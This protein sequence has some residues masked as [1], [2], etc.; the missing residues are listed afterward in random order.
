VEPRDSAIKRLVKASPLGPLAR[1]AAKAY[2]VRRRLILDQYDREVVE[3]MSRVLRKDSNCV[4]AGAH[5]GKILRHMLRL[6]PEGTH[7]AFEPL[8]GLAGELRGA[9]PSAVVMEMA[10]ANVTE[11]ARFRHVL[12]DEAYSGFKRRPWDTYEEAVEMIEVQVRPLDEVLPPELP[13]HFIKADVE[14]SEYQLLQGAVRTLTSNRPYVAFELGSDQEQIFDLLS[15]TGLGTFLLDGWL[16]GSGPL[17][18][19]SFLE[20][21]NNRVFTFLAAPERSAI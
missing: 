9:F 2:R 4:D 7:Y 17:T 20:Q 11:T 16:E 10:L 12:S 13:I 14:G 1:R 18:R 21:V 8:P 15:S 6:A 3:V 5:Q 19:E